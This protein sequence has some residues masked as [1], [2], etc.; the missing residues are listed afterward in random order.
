ML[1]SEDPQK[2]IE[3]LGD[4]SNAFK[5]QSE[6]VNRI[7]FP[8]NENELIAIV[9]EANEKNTLVTISGGGTGIT[10]SRVPM[11]GG[12]VISMEKMLTSVSRDSEEIIFQGLA[13][14][15]KFGLDRPSNIAH[16]PP[17]ISLSELERALPKGLIYPPDPT[18]KSAFLGGTV[19]TN[20]T[21]ARCFYYGPTRSWVV[22]LS[23]VLANGDVLTIRRGE[24]FADKEGLLNFTSESEK[25]YSLQ[26]PNYQMPDVKNAAGLYSR[27]GMDLI[28]LFIGSEGIL[29][30]ISEVSVKLIPSQKE[31]VSILSFFGLETDALGCVDILR[32]MKDRGVLAIE[33]FDRNA[34]DFIR[35]EFQELKPELDAAILLEIDAESMDLLS[36]V[37]GLLARFNESEDR[38]A[39]STSDRRDLKEFRHSLPDSVNAYLKQ[40]ESY[41]I[42]TD[43]VVPVD[44]FPNMMNKY[45]ETGEKFKSRFPRPGTHYVMF[46]HIGDCHIHF[47]FITANDEERACAM[48]LYLELARA[49]I[50]LGGTISG[51]HGVG[52]KTLPVD[53]KAMPYLELMYGVHGIAEIAQVKRVLDP[54]MI[55]NIGNMGVN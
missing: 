33:Y 8:K 12:W 44:K 28:D 7:Y 19:A 54:K 26:I 41:K 14:T 37:S 23:V 17:G 1:F 30:I 49:S 46:G 24:T 53:G 21:G 9:R 31:P 48:E 32:D 38:C 40:H 22:G 45:R 6:K 20:A 50:A 18:E 11:S 10:G 13:G 47:N 4:E 29:G 43:F 42:G 27:P 2:I 52:K 15:I 34:L 36:D 39:T 35:T 16:L 55:L 3:Y 25:K 5:A 51:E